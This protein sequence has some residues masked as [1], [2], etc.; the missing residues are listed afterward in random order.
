MRGLIRLVVVGLAALQGTIAQQEACGDPPSQDKKYFCGDLHRVFLSENG[1]L[2]AC[3]T[4]VSYSRI[5]AK[6]SQ[7]GGGGW[8]STTTSGYKT[9]HSLHSLNDSQIKACAEAARNG[10]FDFSQAKGL[11]RLFPSQDELEKMTDKDITRGL[12]LAQS[13]TA[14][15]P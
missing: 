8:E 5:D 9:K 15:Q 1:V 7:T 12:K 3:M 6:H 2:D 4:A 13:R 10:C 11:R 14:T